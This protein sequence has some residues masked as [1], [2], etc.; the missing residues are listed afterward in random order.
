MPIGDTKT[1]ITWNPKYC[2]IKA[3]SL[4]LL[5]RGIVLLQKQKGFIIQKFKLKF[6]GCCLKQDKVNLLK[7]SKYVYRFRIRYI[8]KRFRY[9]AYT[10]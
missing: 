8:A 7:F 1:I 2:W 10:K 5:Q 9:Q 4:L 6:R 3:L